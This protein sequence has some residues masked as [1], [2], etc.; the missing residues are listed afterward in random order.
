M[1]LLQELIEN[2]LQTKKKRAKVIVISIHL[3]ELQ[4]QI[5][6]QRL[7][8]PLI[9]SKCTEC[10]SVKSTQKLPYKNQWKIQET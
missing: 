3:K 10:T 4:K 5:F 2:P 6:S 1:K 9:V 7:L 8:Y